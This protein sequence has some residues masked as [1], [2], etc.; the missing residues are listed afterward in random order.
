MVRSRLL[1]FERSCASSPCRRLRLF[2]PAAFKVRRRLSRTVWLSRLACALNDSWSL[3]VSRGFDELNDASWKYSCSVTVA[4][5]AESF[6]HELR[7][8]PTTLML[9]QDRNR[10]ES[11]PTR[12]A[13]RDRFGAYRN[14]AN[15]AA[16]RLCD[17]RDCKPTSSAQGIN[18]VLLGVTCVRRSMRRAMARYIAPTDLLVYD[19]RAL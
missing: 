18:D 15:Y 19:E 13:V 10:A 16:V 14:I 7:T 8:D 17:E 9:R 5:K 3:A 6:T 12:C 1:C 11:E 4:K 2:Y